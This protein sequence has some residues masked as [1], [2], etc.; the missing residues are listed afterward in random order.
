MVN[1]FSTGTLWKI[2]GQINRATVREEH[3]CE[4]STE[5]FLSTKTHY[6][7]KP[8]MISSLTNFYGTLLQSLYTIYSDTTVTSHEPGNIPESLALATLENPE[9]HLPLEKVF[10]SMTANKL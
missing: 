6:T 4:K 3:L 2:V 5:F 1:F 10:V 7:K 8:W 9:Y